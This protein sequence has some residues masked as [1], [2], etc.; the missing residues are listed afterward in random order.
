MTTT[1]LYK[2]NNKTELCLHLVK[3]ILISEYTN[4]IN[5]ITYSNYSLFFKL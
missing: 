1:L 3:K 4:F 5:L 2:T